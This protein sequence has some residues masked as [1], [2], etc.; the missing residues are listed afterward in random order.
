MGTPSIN[1]SVNSRIR[2]AGLAG[3]TPIPAACG[4]KLPRPEG[5]HSNQDKKLSSLLSIG[6][7]QKFS[8]G[9]ERDLIF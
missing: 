9:G 8:R 1:V 6:N 5:F 4:R 7:I 3:P 2:P